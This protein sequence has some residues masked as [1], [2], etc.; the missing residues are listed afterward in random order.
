MKAYLPSK[1][2]QVTLHQKGGN[3]ARLDTFLTLLREL[4]FQPVLGIDIL[5]ANSEDH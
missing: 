3:P 4:K 2:L 5:I 1:F